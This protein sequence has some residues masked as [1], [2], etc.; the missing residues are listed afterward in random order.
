MRP[1][2]EWAGPGES[3]QSCGREA[4]AVQ[5]VCLCAVCIR[6]VEVKQRSLRDLERQL[7]E[8]SALL[9]LWGVCKTPANRQLSS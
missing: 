6:S 7:E 3:G 1:Q 4:I 2:K 9:H 5:W 8:G